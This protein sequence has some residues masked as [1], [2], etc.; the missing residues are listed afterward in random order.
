MYCGHLP[1]SLRG[2]DGRGDGPPLNRHE[3]FK[4][5]FQQETREDLQKVGK[6]TAAS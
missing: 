2:G 6:L 5:R 3:K 1:I 4:L